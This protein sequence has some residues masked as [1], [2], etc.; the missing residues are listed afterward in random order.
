VALAIFEQ[1]FQAKED[2][3]MIGERAYLTQDLGKWN[4]LEI[5]WNFFQPNQRGVAA[6]LRAA[7]TE[8]RK[9]Q[10]HNDCVF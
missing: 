7:R 4:L 8:E 5:E 2:K 9:Y 10:G 3:V 1:Q 6:R